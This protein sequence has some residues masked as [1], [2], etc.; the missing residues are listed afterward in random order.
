[1]GHR[2]RNVSA[3]VWMLAAI[4]PAFATT[5]GVCFGMAN[6][7]PSDVLN[8]RV[9]PSARAPIVA[10]FANSSEVILAQVGSCGR[11]CRVAASTQYGTKRGW[12]NARY[13]RRRECP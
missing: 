7:P 4:T 10:R 3:A 9:R 8:M 13:L 2:I 11:W 5:E 6:V 1:M 12:I